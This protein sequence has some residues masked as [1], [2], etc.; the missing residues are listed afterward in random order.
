VEGWT[1]PLVGGGGRF[2]GGRCHGWRLDLIRSVGR[3]GGRGDRGSLG[4]SRGG[5][6]GGLGVAVVGGRPG[7]L[8]SGGGGGRAG[9]GGAPGWWA[10]RGGGGGG[11]GW[12][13][14]VAVGG[15]GGGGLDVPQPQ[16]FSQ[17][18]HLSTGVLGFRLLF[19]QS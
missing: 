17:Q 12:G 11:V 2:W 13:V 8:G 1:L 4:P 9:G 10:G 19:P 5:P 18:I 6:A 15:G 16:S 7:G 3:G 14:V